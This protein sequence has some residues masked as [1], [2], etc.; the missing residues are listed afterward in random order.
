MA[1]AAEGNSSVTLRPPN[2]IRGAGKTKKP[3]H[4]AGFR[5]RQPLAGCALAGWRPRVQT[6]PASAAAA[7]A[8]AQSQP[9]CFGPPGAGRQLV[10]WAQFGQTFRSF[11][12]LSF[13][14]SHKSGLPKWSHVRAAE[15]WPLRV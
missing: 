9:V 11:P 6:R 7:A 4:P 10:K 5:F 13:P 12:F 2:L 3:D 1:A 15:S 8:A 14:F